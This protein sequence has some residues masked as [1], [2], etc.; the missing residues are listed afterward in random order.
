MTQSQI[1]LRV[2]PKGGNQPR[3]HWN[4]DKRQRT[5]S[6]SEDAWYLAGQLADENSSN[7]SEVMEIL[8]R[9]ASQTDL[10]LHRAR[11]EVLPGEET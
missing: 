9:Y 7:R 4:S 8:L 2:R 1:G 11:V 6:L 10:D 5:L 3:T